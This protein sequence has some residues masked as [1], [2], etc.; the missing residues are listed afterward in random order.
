MTDQRKRVLSVTMF[1]AMIVVVILIVTALISFYI[2]AIRVPHDLAVNTAKSVEAWFNFTPRTYIQ[3]TIVIEQNAPILE[4]A[5]VSRSIFVDYAWNHTW[6]GS[7]KTL[8]LTGV[9]TAKAG[10]DLREPFDIII[11]KNPVRVVASLSPP[12]VLSV[13]MDTFLV[14]RDESGWW[15]RIS[16]LDRQL[17]VNA[18]Q[19][20]ARNRAAASGILEEAQK[21]A[22]ERLRKIA[23]W[24]G[25]TVEFQEQGRRK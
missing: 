17:A 11:E 12:K 24:N 10:F 6:L 1:V 21:T 16:P 2:L 4:V 13:Q 19:L 18:L 14:V 23:E 20:T 7:T 25:S 9:F 15:N 8:Q 22:E 5:T 3:E